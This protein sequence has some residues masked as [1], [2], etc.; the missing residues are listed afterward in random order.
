MRRFA[1]CVLL[2]FL[3]GCSEN[4]EINDGLELRTRLLQS[5][6][7]SFSVCINVDYGQQLYNFSM[8]CIADQQ[9]NIRF[10]VTE[11]E[12]I[13]GICGQISSDG[14]ALMFDN[15]AL[16]VGLLADN[17]LSPVSAP[18]ILMNTLRSGCLTSAC[19]EDGMIRLSL[20]DRYEEDALHLDVWLDTDNLPQHAD[21]LHNG[22]RVLSLDVKNVVIV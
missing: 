12:T 4:K 3:A 22:I 7:C 9:G 11:P 14:G 21:I 18:W 8:D 13:S 10:T 16:D 5:R 19:R 6:E 15:V 20:D 2:F 1:V 17:Q